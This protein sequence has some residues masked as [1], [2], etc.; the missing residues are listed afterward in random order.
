[1]AMSSDQ[2][3][4]VVLVDDHPLVAAGLRAELVRHGIT[5]RIGPIESIEMLLADLVRCPPEL[6]VLDYVMGVLGDAPSVLPLI[7]DL[8]LP[9]VV[10]SG[11]ADRLALAACLEL[12]AEAVIAKDET[13]DAIVGLVVDALDGRCRLDSKAL[14]MMSELSAARAE[15]ARA[16]AVFTELTVREEEVL[17]ALMQGIA[18]REIARESFVSIETVRSQIKSVLRKLG[19]NSQLEAVAI[20]YRLGWRSRSTS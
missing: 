17:A 6:V 15:H 13:I 18:A 4:R 2:R 10:L 1:M 9:V 11:S 3:E 19:A 5:T 16:A 20:A 7:V 12:G 14:K 8:E